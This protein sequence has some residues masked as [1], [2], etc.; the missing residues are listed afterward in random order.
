[1]PLDVGEFRFPIIYDE[2]FTGV[3]LEDDDTQDDGKNVNK[4]Q[5]LIEDGTMAAFG[6]INPA[7]VKVN[8]KLK[9]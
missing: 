9:K 3:T 1:M 6:L 7:E 4:Q 2:N 8:P 5:I